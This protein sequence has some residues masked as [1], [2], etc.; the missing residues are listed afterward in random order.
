M[1][2]RRLSVLYQVVI[3]GGRRISTPPEDGQFCVIFR[4]N[5]T[6][7]LSAAVKSLLQLTSAHTILTP[8]RL[9][10]SCEI[11][12]AR[13]VAVVTPAWVVRHDSNYTHQSFRTKRDWR[14]QTAP[15]LH[16]RKNVGHS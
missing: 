5:A 12:S 2:A 11:V 6:E 9:R 4:Q 10:D 16:E 3:H 13:R 1:S 8:T 7:M 14:D 15:K